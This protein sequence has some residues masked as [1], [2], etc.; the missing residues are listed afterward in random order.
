M[1]LA[2]S[3][4]I[5]VSTSMSVQMLARAI[6]LVCVTSG[7]AFAAPVTRKNCPECV[8]P[9]AMDSTHE[10]VVRSAREA[11]REGEWSRA[12]ELWRSALL[13]DEHVAEHWIAMGDALSGAQRH[14]EAVAS[15]QR[16][17][18]LDPRTARE[19]TRRVA[20]AYALMGN[21]KQAVRWLEQALRAGAVVDELL[22]DDVFARYRGEPRLRALL[23]HQVELRGKAAGARRGE[24]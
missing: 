15:Y 16:S 3:A 5:S 6:A 19:S 24:A 9:P 22:E 23:E 11:S 2:A 20:R 17:I 13:R 14:R 7:A 21:D 10:L 1:A 18:Q 8:V 4:A 12:A